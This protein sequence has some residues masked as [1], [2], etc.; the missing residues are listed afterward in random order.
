MFGGLP[1]RQ[2]G[3]EG[4]FMKATRYTTHAAL[5][6]EFDTLEAL[7]AIINRGETTVCHRLSGK[8][9]WTATEK[10]LI[11]D[12]LIRRGVETARTPETFNKYF[13]GET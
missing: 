7:G 4:D 12:D 11:I 13:G 10:G 8:T 5:R 1:D 6:R 2:N 3:S 9:P